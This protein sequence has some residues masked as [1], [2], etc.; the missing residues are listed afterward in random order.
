MLNLWISG[1][2]CFRLPGV[3]IQM[4]SGRMIDLIINIPLEFSRK[5]RSLNELSHWKATEF[6]LFIL[7]L[8]SVVL[9]NILSPN[10]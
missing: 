3:K 10:V 5:P 8:G 1:P 2:L 4:F 7:Y 6:G 9:K